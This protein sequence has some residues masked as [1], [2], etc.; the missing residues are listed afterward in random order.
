MLSLLPLK[1]YPCTRY[2]QSIKYVEVF[3]KI[4]SICLQRKVDSRLMCYF[5][6]YKNWL[7][8]KRKRKKFSRK[9]GERFATNKYSRIVT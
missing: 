4:A 8:F 6:N 2:V 9:E 5:I 3:L 7:P 1:F